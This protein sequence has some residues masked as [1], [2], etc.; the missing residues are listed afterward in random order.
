MKV[1][2]RYIRSWYIA[3]NGEVSHKCE[4]EEFLHEMIDN[5]RCVNCNSEIPIDILF[6]A[7][8]IKALG[9]PRIL[10]PDS[11]SLISKPEEFSLI[12]SP[13]SKG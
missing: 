1:E 6:K 5:E 7:K 2:N 10:H 12:K 9:P 8:K 4:G 13:S 11:V 3:D